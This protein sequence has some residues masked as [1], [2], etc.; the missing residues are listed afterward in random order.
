[1]YKFLDTHFTSTLNLWMKQGFEGKTRAQTQDDFADNPKPNSTTL[2][3]EPDQWQQA[4]CP[5]RTC[6]ACASGCQCEQGYLN[7][8]SVNM[9]LMIEP[10]WEGCQV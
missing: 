9:T 3:P 4:V 6:A 1:V 7:C 5:L 2:T 10:N 8:S